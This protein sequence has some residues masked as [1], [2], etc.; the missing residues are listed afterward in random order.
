ML[1]LKPGGR[2]RPVRVPLNRVVAL[3]GAP[4]WDQNRSYREGAAA[5]LLPGDPQVDDYGPLYAAV[6]QVNAA[7]LE[8]NIYGSLY[9]KAR[10]CC[11]HW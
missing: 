3:A 1:A 10:R 8:R 9:L 2:H 7:A 6:A 11:R 4:R 5:E